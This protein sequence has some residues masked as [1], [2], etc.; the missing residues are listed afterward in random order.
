MRRVFEKCEVSGLG[1][2]ISSVSCLVPKG[3]SLGCLWRSDPAGELPR[4]VGLSM[5]SHKSASLEGL[6]EGVWLFLIGVCTVAPRG[7]T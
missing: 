3:L 4:A 6:V 1:G 7:H 2:E 5:T